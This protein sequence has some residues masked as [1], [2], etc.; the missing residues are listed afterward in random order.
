MIRDYFSL[1]FG[2]IKTKGLRSWLTILGIFIGIA[3][4]VSLISLGAGLKTAV[5]G[6]FSS[7]SVDKLTIQNKGTGFGPPG[8][9]VVEKL[10]KEDARIIS[11]VDGV[12]IIIERLLRVAKFEYNDIS[13]FSYLVSLPED[14]EKLQLTYTEM[15]MEIKDGRFPGIEDSGKILVGETLAEG[16]SF[17]KEIL[18][19]KK[20]KINGKDFE[21]MGILD[22]AI[23]AQLNNV[24]FMGEED[25]KEILDFTDEYDLIV[26]QVE[27]QDELVEVAKKIEDELRKDRKEEIGEESFSVE[28]PLQAFSVVS[29]ILN[30]INLI[31]VGIAN[32]MYAS[33]LE[34]TKEIGVMKA[35]GAKNSDIMWIFLIESGLLGLVG[36]IIGALMGLGGAMLVS[37]LANQALGNDLFIVSINYYLLFGAVAFSFFVG[38]ISGVLPAIQASKLNVVEALRS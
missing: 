18:V 27:D 9:T 31:V 5:M 26:A 19:G 24:I 34:R 20:I 2:N 37:N 36:G 10:N 33:V 11:E 21:V 28:T 6:Q 12:E 38:I 22:G 3:A 16:K 25:L 17:D 4:V 7:L 8:S 32:T 13:I 35:I 1:S 30:V 23:N 29:T 14:K 15:Q